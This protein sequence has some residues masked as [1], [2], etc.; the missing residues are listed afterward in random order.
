MLKQ[1]L[2]ND[3]LR[4]FWIKI[5]VND[6]TVNFNSVDYI[7]RTG[8]GTLKRVIIKRY[9]PNLTITSSFVSK[10]SLSSLLGFKEGNRFINII[11]KDKLQITKLLLKVDGHKTEGSQ[12][13]S[14]LHFNTSFIDLEPYRIYFYSN[15]N[16]GYDTTGIGW[17]KD[18]SCFIVRDEIDKG[19][20]MYVDF[21][22]YSGKFLIDNISIS[23]LRGKYKEF[24]TISLKLTGV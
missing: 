3:D 22:V 14:V 18:L 12:Q 24:F 20:L 8:D 15:I 13:C 23:P 4:S 16:S 1:L 10:E 9:I 6:F 7:Y 19:T 17:D 2:I 11:F 21:Y 5:P